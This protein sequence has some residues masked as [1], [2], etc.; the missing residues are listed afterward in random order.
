V[1]GPDQWFNTLGAGP[2]VISHIILRT[3]FSPDFKKVPVNNT[4]FK[5][6]NTLMVCIACTLEALYR[7]TFLDSSC[8]R[9]NIVKPR[10]YN[11]L[12]YSLSCIWREIIDLLL[13]DSN[14]A[15]SVMPK[16]SIR[17]DIKYSL[18]PKINKYV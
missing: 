17:L 18:F 11:Y 2:Q 6:V 16:I 15:R 13:F 12:K 4:S 5:T 1:L 14:S 10:Q 7:C 9:K 3:V 8:P